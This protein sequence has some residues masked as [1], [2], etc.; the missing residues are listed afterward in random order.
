MY[1]D[2]HAHLEDAKFANDLPDVIARAQ[3][4][5]VVSI[6]NNGTNPEHNRQTLAIAEKYPMV[7]AALGLHPTDIASLSDAQIAEELIF[8]QSQRH[9]LIALGEIGLDFHWHKESHEHDRQ[10]KVFEQIIALGEKLKL[11]LIV[12]TRKAEAETIEMLKSS[13]VRKVDLHCFSG[14]MRLVQEAAE[15]GWSFSIPANIVFS[16]HFQ[17]LVKQV[18]LNQLLTETDCPFLGPVKG[19]RNEPMNVVRTVK[20]ISEIKGFDKEEVKNNIWYNYSR[21]FSN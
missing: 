14:S 2:I 20:K 8:I 11:P 16:T 19:E 12:H 9:N 1:I 4:A 3:A 6:I 18:E 5:G 17:E 21:M 15:Q 10:R 7:K 13:R